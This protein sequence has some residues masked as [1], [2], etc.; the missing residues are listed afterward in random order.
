MVFLASRCWALVQFCSSIR[1]PT[2][3]RW[4]LAASM[5]SQVSRPTPSTMLWIYHISIPEN[6]TLHLVLTLP[7]FDHLLLQWD[8]TSRGWYQATDLSCKVS[9]SQS[10]RSDMKIIV[11]FCFCLI[12]ILCHLFLFVIATAYF[13]TVVWMYMPLSNSLDGPNFPI[14]YLIY[15]SG[16]FGS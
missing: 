11:V 1:P 5:K 13:S 2:A 7:R 8:H 3:T 9:Q 4:P 16:L 6:E 12:Y 15:N 10:E 14:T